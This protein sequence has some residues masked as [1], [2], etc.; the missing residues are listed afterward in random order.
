MSTTTTAENRRN[1]IM[2][3]TIIGALFFIFGFI[4][5]LN[6]TLIP[7]L[8]IACELNNVQAYFVTLAFYIAYFF[9][10]PPS[11]WVLHKTGFKNGMAL[12]LFIIAIGSLIFIPAALS[13]TFGLFL[14]GL[15][16][17]GTG[18]AL[19]QTAS[20]PYV[21]VLG[22]RESAA[23]RIAI[24]GIC[25]KV[26]GAISP[27]ILGAVVLNQ[28]TTDIVES[29]KSIT[30]IERI[31]MLDSLAH[32]VIVPYIIIAIALTLLSIG[33]KFLHLP[34]VDTDKE[35]DSVAEKGTHKTAWYQ[36]PHL[37]LGFITLFLYVGVEVMAGD[38][39]ILYGLSQ[40][41]PL[42]TAR[43]F[44]T[45]TLLAMV[46]GYVIGI[47]TIPRLISQSKALAISAVTGVL[48]SLAAIFTSGF[49]SVACIALLGLS[50]AIMWPA[51]FPLS[52]ADLGKFTKAGSA[53]LVMG[54]AG[55]ALIPLG[56]GKMVETMGNQQAYW[57]MVPIYLFIFY[58]AVKGHKIRS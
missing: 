20:N 28:N 48:F 1:Y 31:P 41:I 11:S 8:K 25:N 33:L 36:F 55:G 16:I 45:F 42:A 58:F 5:W 15:F 35:E 30:G 7:F 2:S 13:R 18:L 37:W 38:T 56:Y 43:T 47:A 32:K 29:L 46:V 27:L 50:N 26:A 52:I 57:I 24:M 22:P 21:V 6:G 51:I 3:I 17:Q 39:I 53:L 49:T 9:M 19:L 44:T 14:T 40:D 4:T 10:A 23:K 54:I 12:G 34:D